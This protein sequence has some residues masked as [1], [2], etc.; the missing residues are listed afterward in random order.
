MTSTA[1]TRAPA[2]T[3]TITAD[4]P[5]PPQPCTA[6]QS[7]GRT[8]PCWTT[9]RYAVANRQPSAAAVSAVELVRQRDEVHVGVVEGDQLGEGAP[10]GEAGL[11][12]PVADLVV[13]GQAGPAG[14]A[15]AHER[16]RDPVADLPVA[17]LRTGLGDRPGELVAGDVR[18]GDGAVV[19]GPAVPVAAA[20][21]GRLDP[22]HDTVGGRDRVGHVTDRDR[23][24]EVVQHQC[25]H[26]RRGYCGSLHTSWRTPRC[27]TGS[28]QG[29]DAP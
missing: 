6:T 19:A 14:A 8:R 12:L 9:A 5:T 23:A 25:P 22:D 17:H 7:P 26:D 2:A 13:A 20:Q 4:S 1:T 16:H 24:A 28:S 10:A 29:P 21:P 27:L 15:G 3:A 11:G 18:Q